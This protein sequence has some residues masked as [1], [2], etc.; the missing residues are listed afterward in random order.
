MLQMLHCLSPAP[1]SKADMDVCTD[2]AFVPFDLLDDT[3][4]LAILRCFGEPHALAS[5][6]LVSQRFAALCTES[7]IWRPLLHAQLPAPH[8][9]KSYFSWPPCAPTSWRERYKQW[10]TLDSLSWAHCPPA[11]G[12]PLPSTRFLHRAAAV[13]GDKAYVY[14][15]RGVDGELG[16]VWRIQ[17]DVA[18]ASGTAEWTLVVPRSEHVPIARLSATLSPVLLGEPTHHG[19]LMFGGRCGE[20]FLNDTWLFDTRNA[21]WTM[22]CAHS[23]HQL[24]PADALPPPTDRHAQPDGRWA[25]SAITHSGPAGSEVIV[26]GGSAP[27][28][29]YNDTHSF[30]IRSHKWERHES[31]GGGPSA[32][33]GHS[34]CAVGMSMYVFGGNTTTDSFNDLWEYAMAARVWTQVRTRVR[35]A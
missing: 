11:H 3:L 16:D 17:C 33:S 15:G 25:H 14:G 32:R 27:G 2:P 1:S 29:C 18:M 8:G 20:S 12:A 13:S 26:F 21:A 6:A 9:H 19:L 7:F 35:K 31:S 28:R 34:V 10:H 22:L 4:V 24:N 23:P 5:A 30:H